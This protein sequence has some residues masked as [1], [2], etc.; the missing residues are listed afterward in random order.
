[1]DLEANPE[2]KSDP[3]EPPDPQKRKNTK[4]NSLN[5]G[6]TQMTQILALA[7]LI[8]AASSA[9]IGTSHSEI[10]IMQIDSMKISRKTWITEE[11][12]A[13][14]QKI[15]KIAKG[16]AIISERYIQEAQTIASE[17]GDPVNIKKTQSRKNKKKH[18]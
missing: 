3:D 18:Y 10:S 2:K 1:M 16:T 17:L 6:P 15:L 12:Q 8:T 7:F 4:L 13:G 14:P 5:Y 11:T 9:Q